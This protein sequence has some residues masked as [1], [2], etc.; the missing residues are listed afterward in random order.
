MPRFKRGYWGDG[1]LDSIKKAIEA[2][3][4]GR[5][6]RPEAQ[7]EPI[8]SESILR[9]RDWIIIVIVVVVAFVLVFKFGLGI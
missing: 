6:Y 5:P 3:R 7:A 8:Q 2:R 9:T 4:E 1:I